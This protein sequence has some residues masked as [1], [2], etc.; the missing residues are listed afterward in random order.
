VKLEYLPAGSS[1]C[2]LIRLYN[3]NKEEVAA[4]H[5]RAVELGTGTREEVQLDQELN[6]VAIAGCSLS[7]ARAKSDYGVSRT[8]EQNHYRC[9][10][11][12]ESWQT[13]AGLIEPFLTPSAVP[14]YQWLSEI[15]E[16]NLLLSEDGAW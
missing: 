2:P 5:V 15:G 3:F 12:E 7:L 10:L 11:T 4:L 1:D 6:M 8:H 13:V 14:R 16:T 9:A